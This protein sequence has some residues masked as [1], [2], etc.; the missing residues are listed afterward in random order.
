[1]ENYVAIIPEAV[2]SHG[3]RISRNKEDNRVMVV[4]KS[5]GTS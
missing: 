3:E 1:M 5:Q 2:A 4:L